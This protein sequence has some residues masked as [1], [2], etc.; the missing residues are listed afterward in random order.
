MLLLLYVNTHVCIYYVLRNKCI[1]VFIKC[2][3]VCGS[4]RMCVSVHILRKCIYVICICLLFHVFLF[5]PCFIHLFVVKFGHIIFLIPSDFLRAY[6]GKIFNLTKWPIVKVKHWWLN[7]VHCG[8]VE[9][10]NGLYF[11][12]LPIANCLNRER[13]RNDHQLLLKGD[14]G[15]ELNEN[16]WEF[17]FVL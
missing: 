5:I 4:V 14:S 8:S 11:L 9:I 16:W 15:N 13:K 6:L 17:L 10:R 3:Y 7:I 1:Y 12:L 2:I